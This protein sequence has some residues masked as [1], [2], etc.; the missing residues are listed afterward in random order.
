MYANTTGLNNLIQTAV[1]LFA[2]YALNNQTYV[3]NI[4]EKKRFL[5][6]FDLYSMHFNE[7]TPATEKTFEYIPGTDKIHAHI[8]GFN[9]SALVDADLK[10]ILNTLNFKNTGINITNMKVDFTL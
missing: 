1:P 10:L 7:A 9:L 8:G 5:Y 3:L 6:T 2:Y 4:S